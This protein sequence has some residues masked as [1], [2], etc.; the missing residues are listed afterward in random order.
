[1]AVERSAGLTTIAGLAEAIARTC[2]EAAEQAMQIAALA[3]ELDSSGD[4][5][6]IRDVLESQTLDS[7]ELSDTRARSAATEIAD[8]LKR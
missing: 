5:G 4:V 8:A 7:D 2:P 3:R 6:T 1:M